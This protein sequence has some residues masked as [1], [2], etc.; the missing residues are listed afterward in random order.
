MIKKTISSAPFTHMIRSAFAMFF[1]FAG[2]SRPAWAERQEIGAANLENPFEEA[3]WGLELT[4][5]NPLEKAARKL[6]QGDVQ[7]M[8]S[9]RYRLSTGWLLGAHAGFKSLRRKEV[10]GDQPHAVSILSFGYESLKGWR[11]YHP[12][13]FFAGGKLHYL[14]PAVES[15][16]PVR[17]DAEFSAE[18][19]ASAVAMLAVKPA[20]NWLMLA[21]M[22]RWRGLATT[23]LQGQ[24]TS[25]G[26]MY[27]F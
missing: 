25:I 10:S 21:R 4:S 22:D 9:Y 16:L 15:T 7:P 3:Y 14:L 2:L 1:L 12:L 8:I 26:L 20:G 6:A 17:R 11:I 5:N 19:G 13:Y 24:E 23:R 18:F 27:S